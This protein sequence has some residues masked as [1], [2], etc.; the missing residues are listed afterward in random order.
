MGDWKE[1]YMH[2]E[3][4]L[5]FANEDNYYGEFKN[6]LFDGVNLNMEKFQKDIKVWYKA[7]RSGKINAK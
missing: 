3:G 6:G 1:G 4:N 5:W 7:Y 2:G